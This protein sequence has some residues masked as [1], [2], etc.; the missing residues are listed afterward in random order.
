M[1]LDNSSREYTIIVHPQRQEL[2]EQIGAMSG[3]YLLLDDNLEVLYVG[4][5]VNIP[6][7]LGSHISSRLIPFTSIAYKI[8]YDLDNNEM[9]LLWQYLPP[10]CGQSYLPNR[11]F[12]PLNQFASQAESTLLSSAQN[13]SAY[14]KRYG[15][16][17][18]HLDIYSI[19]GKE[20]IV[21]KHRSR[22]GPRLLVKRDKAEKWLQEIIDEAAQVA[23]RGTIEYQRVVIL[24]LP[25]NLYDAN[26]A[27]N[28]LLQQY[29]ISEFSDTVIAVNEA[30]F[31]EIVIML[32]SAGYDLDAIHIPVLA[33]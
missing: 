21:K 32:E 24:Y 15:K 26:M 9:A 28:E 17:P 3:V 13:T 11:T 30:A 20:Y 5:S 19:L 16:N 33:L 4:Q 8:C 27:C 2:V 1:R 12:I 23:I 29:V 14:V 7:R 10:Y 31:K 25:T 22:Q 18:D 6:K